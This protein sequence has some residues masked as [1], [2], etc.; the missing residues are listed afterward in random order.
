MNPRASDSDGG[1]MRAVVF[2]L[3]ELAHYHFTLLGGVV[4]GGGLFAAAEEEEDKETDK[5][6]GDR[7][8][9]SEAYF[10]AGG[11]AAAGFW[12]LNVVSG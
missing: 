2:G 5:D 6:E 1:G 12:G 4:A 3:V 7:D 10:S 8:A 9:D 11:K